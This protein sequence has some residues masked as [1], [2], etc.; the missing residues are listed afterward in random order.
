LTIFCHLPN[1]NHDSYCLFV[2]HTNYL[3]NCQIQAIFHK[4]GT[5]ETV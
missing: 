4:V 3:L 5:G 1:L 2:S